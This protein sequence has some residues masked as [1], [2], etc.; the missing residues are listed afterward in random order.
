MLEAAERQKIPY[1]VI[2]LP[3][4]VGIGGEQGDVAEARDMVLSDVR[5]NSGNPRTFRRKRSLPQN[6]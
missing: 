4:V 1:S 5:I 6:M 3:S 2:K